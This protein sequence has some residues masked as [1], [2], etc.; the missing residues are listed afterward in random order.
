MERFC[1]VMI[2]RFQSPGVDQPYP[3]NAADEYLIKPFAMRELLLRIDELL[4]RRG[5]PVNQPSCLELGDLCLDLLQQQ[6]HCGRRIV[7]LSDE[8]C[9]IDG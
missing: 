5:L 3:R 4:R 6:V 7:D 8:E 9:T 2:P 1:L